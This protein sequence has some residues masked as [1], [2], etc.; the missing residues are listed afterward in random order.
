M[1]RPVSQLPYIDLNAERYWRGLPQ[2]KPIF[3]MSPADDLSFVQDIEGSDDRDYWVV[4]ATGK[5]GDWETGRRLADEFLSYLTVCPF[6][7]HLLGSIVE[8]MAQK[9][10]SNVNSGFLN[11]IG[12]YARAAATVIDLGSRD[13]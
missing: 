11:R 6:G 10:W 4:K 5:R 2:P 13:E 8:S 3:G 12:H 1:P 9:E 7:G